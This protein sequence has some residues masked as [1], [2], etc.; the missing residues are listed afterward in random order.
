MTTVAVNKIIIKP[1]VVVMLETTRDH[2]RQPPASHTNWAATMY[3]GRGGRAASEASGV[4]VVEGQPNKDEDGC[5]R[6]TTRLT[7]GARDTDSGD[8]EG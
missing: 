5:M 7:S 1:T 3:P 6:R 4:N 8:Q 2:V